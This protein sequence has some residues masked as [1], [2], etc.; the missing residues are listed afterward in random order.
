MLDEMIN[1]EITEVND[2]DVIDTNQELTTAEDFTVLTGFKNMSVKDWAEFVAIGVGFTV[3]VS[4][5]ATGITVLAAT[6]IDKIKSVLPFGKKKKDKAEE[7]ENA[8][9]KT[10]GDSDQAGKKK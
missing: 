5:I 10:D 2:V 8:N 4:W 6:A 9:N 7:S 1:E 3:A